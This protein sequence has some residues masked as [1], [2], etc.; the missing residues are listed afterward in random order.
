MPLI[1]PTRW[2]TALTLAAGLAQMLMGQLPLAPGAP[3]TGALTATIKT[4]VD[5]VVLD[6]IAR[7]KKGKPVSDLK[8][9]E[10]TVTDNGTKQNI[11][12]FRLVQGSEAITQTGTVKLDPLH[13]V[14]LVTLAFEPMG[15]A[16]QRKTARTAA[17]DLIKGDQGTN[18]FYSVVAMN[19]R[20]LVLQ[21]FTSDK[22]ALATAIDRATAGTSATKLISE[23]D[24][25]Q[26]ELK[27]Q[28]GGDTVNGSNQTTDLIAIA[29]Q[30][31]SQPPGP[32]MDLT[33]AVLA[34]VMLDMLRFDAAAVSSGSRLSLNALKSLVQALQ[35]MP[36]RKS[37]L[38]FTSGLYLGNE[39]DTMFENLKGAANRANVTFY[40]VD[41]RGVMTYSQ[42]GSAA[43]QLKSAANA[44]ASLTTRTSGAVTK[45]EVL[46]SDNA[47][48]AGRN[49]TQLKIREL[50]ESTGGFLIGDS[51][52]LRGPLRKVNEEI[53]SYYEI[54]FNPDIRN[55]DGSFRKLSVGTSRKDVVLSARTGYF[56][57]P[58]EARSSG[59]DAFEIPLL[60]AIS[61][62]KVSDDFK[63][64]AGAV[65]LRPKSEGTEVSILLEV[66]MRELKAKSDTAKNT[67]DVHCSLGG[68]LK[69][70]KGEVVQK[71]TRDR[72][73]HV[74]PEQLKAGNF[75][76]KTQ[77]VL[78]PG[79]YTF[80][81]AVIDRESGKTGM[82]RTSFEVEPSPKGVGI[83]SMTAI[84]A[85]TANVKGLDPAEPFQ[86]QGGSITPTMNSSVARTADSAI[87]LFFIVYQ[88]PAIQ[89]K[90][91]V[92]VEFLQG[93]KS[94]TKVP[95]E[96]PAAD[97]MGK[98][99]YVMTIPA[100]AIPPG[101][102]QLQATAKQGDSSAMTKAEVKVE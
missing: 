2:L 78:M 32:G 17:L 9:S 95:M 54:T 58:P 62:G 26:S 85:Y 14:R 93:G 94:L 22:A 49:N 66:P 12:G 57:L 20:L 70:S 52:D 4:T 47:E 33:K 84:R 101:T 10:I 80:E 92:E 15:E 102:Y 13:Q 34:R 73:F 75:I 89:T 90:P 63:Y 1:N 5:E 45:D 28:L 88:D 16:D 81:T 37:V 35:P 55:Y 68:L 43:A 99:A 29:N 77:V 19:T 74:T 30:A 38:Y 91:T 61:E 8:A 23:S 42:N 50:A 6:L 27:R 48:N 96:L 41:T 87:R 65:L 11:L 18:V 97:A 31:A 71:I 100:A 36:G 59:M 82:Q 44:S 72:S 40:S 67:L 51:N 21:P 60:K 64:R 24:A 53:S 7:D 76:E 25:I 39:L 98:I 86:F 56:A 79:K 83:S 46:A 69:D 3:G